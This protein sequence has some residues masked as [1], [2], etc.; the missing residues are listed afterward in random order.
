MATLLVLEPIGGIAG[1]MFL[2]AALDLGVPRGELE[3]LLATLPLG[4]FRLE[5]TAAEAGGLRGT[6]VKVVAEGPS[7]E[8]GLR[9]VLEV[10][11][12]SGLSARAREAARAVFVRI[13]RAEATVHGLPIESVHFHEIGAVDSIVDVCGAAAALDLLG[14]PRLCATPP[15]LGQGL[16]ETAH[17]RLPVPAP[18]VLEIL[19]GTPVKLGGP[20]GE[21][22]T[23]TGAALLATL[24]EVGD[25][26]PIVPE[27]VGYGVGTARWPDR[28]N[29][30][31]LTLGQAA[32]GERRLWVLEAN[33]DDCPGQLVARA[34]E[35]ALA[36]GAL[37]AWAA[38]LTMKKGRPGFLVGALAEGHRRDAVARVILAETTTLGVR[39]HPVERTELAREMVSVETAYGAVR[40][41]VARDGGRVAGAQPEYEDCAA[42]ARDKGVPVREVMAAALSAWRAGGRG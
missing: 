12:Q 11:D 33:L 37:D 19:K 32:A 39:W 27:R 41:K 8:R 14:W 38:P 9:Q 3:R 1:D 6:H 26:P 16:V 40:V 21:A 25:P 5:V 36:A 17:G 2:A 13:G 4:G 18:A 7:P 29:V 15:E 35:A 20:P 10:V 30:L 28:P 24:C 22:V 34:I 23:P 31:R 42:L